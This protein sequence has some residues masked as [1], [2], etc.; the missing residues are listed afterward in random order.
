M[1]ATTWIGVIAAPAATVA[2]VGLLMVGTVLGLIVKAS[3]ITLLV[4]AALVALRLVLK[5]PLAVGVPV[6][7]PVLVLSDRPAGK[8]LG[9]TTA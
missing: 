7:A 8:V 3:A 9:A 4:P 6:I 5:L 1:V 2:K